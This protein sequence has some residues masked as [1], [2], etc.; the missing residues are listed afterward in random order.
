M[1]FPQNI[2]MGQMCMTD[3]GTTQDNFILPAQLVGGLPVSQDP[4]DILKLVRDRTIPIIL[5]SGN[6]ILV[7]IVFKISVRHTNLDTKKI[8]SRLGSIVCLFIA[9]NAN[10]AGYLTQNNV[11]I[12]SIILKDTLSY[13]HPNQGMVQLRM[14]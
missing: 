11:F 8:Q 9:P 7:N 5:P 6:N 12:S 3:A 13:H 10:M 1:I 2:R 4:L 14:L